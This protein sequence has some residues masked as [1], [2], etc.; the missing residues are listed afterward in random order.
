MEYTVPESS[1]A[2]KEVAA[3]VEYCK[4]ALEAV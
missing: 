3:C 2:V 1:D 4:R